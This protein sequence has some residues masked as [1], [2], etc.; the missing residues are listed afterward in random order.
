[1]QITDSE[2]TCSFK[3]PNMP[4]HSITQFFF[5]RDTNPVAGC[6]LFFFSILYSSNALLSIFKPSKEGFYEYFYELTSMGRRREH[7]VVF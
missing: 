7:P 4:V 6:H 5:T 3:K 1:M 2:E